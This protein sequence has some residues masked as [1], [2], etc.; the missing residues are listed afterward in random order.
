M[1]RS[2]TT[3]HMIHFSPEK[4]E[5]QNHRNLQEDIGLFS[6]EEQEKITNLQEE[7]NNLV[8]SIK[9]PLTFIN[10]ERV[11]CILKELTSF[12]KKLQKNESTE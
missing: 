7:L 8:G 10:N 6:L 1:G 3:K 9:N 12:H 5:K 4:K 2:L 11:T